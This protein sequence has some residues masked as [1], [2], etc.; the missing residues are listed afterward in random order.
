VNNARSND[1]AC[2]CEGECQDSCD[3]GSSGAR[4]EQRY[5]NLSKQ[6]LPSSHES[7]V[8]YFRSQP[9]TLDFGLEFWTAPPRF[10][11]HPLSLSATPTLNHRSGSATMSDDMDTPAQPRASRFREH[12]NTS[13]SI[14]P[15]PDELWKDI[16]IDDMMEKFSE[17]SNAPPQRKGSQK[18]TTP[19]D[20]G[21]STFSGTTATPSAH[22]GTFGRFSR[23]FASVF[24]SV[25]G[26]RKAGNPDA[27]KDKEKQMLDERKAAAEQAYEARKLAQEMGLMPTPKVFV[28]P[29]ATP[30][31][32]KCG[33]RLAPFMEEREPNTAQLPS[34][35]LPPLRPDPPAC[36]SPPRKRICRSR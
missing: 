23:A 36:T 20:M 1:M 12:T 21:S 19:S 34:T 3:A 13:N 6:T 5:P 22:E 26:K 17:E 33:K 24:G 18:S 25:L 30:R 28:R 32:H 35:L 4:M 15:P 31:S 27:E 2:T 29:T 7:L 11:S 10:H 9:A 14:K 16:Q 8:P